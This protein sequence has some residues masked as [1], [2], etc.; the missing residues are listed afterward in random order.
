MKSKKQQRKK[1]MLHFAFMDGMIDWINRSWSPPRNPELF[2][3]Y[4]RG[5]DY[6]FPNQYTI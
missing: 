4:C 1:V 2:K 6:V 3:E 5:Y